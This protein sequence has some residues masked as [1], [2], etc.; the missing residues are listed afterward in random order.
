MGHVFCNLQWIESAMQI[1]LGKE[2]LCLSSLAVDRISVPEEG[3]IN[4]PTH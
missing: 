4:F 1:F 2:M 3:L